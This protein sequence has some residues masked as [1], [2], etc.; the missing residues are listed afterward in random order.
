MKNPIDDTRTIHKPQT[1]K[2]TTGDIMAFVYYVQVEQVN[3]PVNLLR[4]RDI[5]NGGFIDVRGKE[6]IENGYSANQFA[7]EVYV[8]KTKAAE[9]LV[10]SHNRPFTVSFQKNDGTERVLKG[11]LV[12]P[13]PLLGRSVVEDLETKDSNR[14][15]QVDHRTVNYIVV[16]GMKYIVK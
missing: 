12:K 13:E 7:E 9:I 8:N 5:D 3:A 10:S 11:R 4:V 2:V 6:L 15:R 16:E 14:I 1:D